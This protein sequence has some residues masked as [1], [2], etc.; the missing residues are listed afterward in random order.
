M[1]IARMPPGSRMAST[2][3]KNSRVKRWAGSVSDAKDD[4]IVAVRRMLDVSAAVLHDHRHARRE[5][6]EAP[7]DRHERD[8][9]RR[10]RRS[11][12]PRS[13]EARCRLRARCRGAPFGFGR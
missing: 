4:E 2:R 8:P 3:T 5:I 10:W 12:P 1:L 11:A 6:E 7:R 13:F 9:P